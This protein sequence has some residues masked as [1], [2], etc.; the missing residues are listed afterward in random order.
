VFI[1]DAFVHY[2]HRP[3]S[4]LGSTHYPDLN[5]LIALASRSTSPLLTSWGMSEVAGR[6]V[7]DAVEQARYRYSLLLACRERR[8]AALGGFLRQAIAR[9]NGRKALWA[10]A[11]EA[12][13]GCWAHLRL[14]NRSN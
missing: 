3:R 6:R 4:T 1:D 11:R 12:V 8:P 7:I 14:R 13:G 10:V 5:Q 2:M 9:P